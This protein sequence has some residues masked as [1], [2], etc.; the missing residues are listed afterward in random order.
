[1]TTNAAA[2]PA[3]PVD[4]PT[5]LTRADY[6]AALKRTIAEIKADDAPSLAAGVAFRMFLSLFPSMFAAVAVFSLVTSQA[7]IVDL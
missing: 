7:E 6:L 4:D 1:M 3:Q 2:A 5:D